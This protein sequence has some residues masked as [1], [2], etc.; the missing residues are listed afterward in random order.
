MFL[1]YALIHQIGKIKLDASNNVVPIINM[2]YLNNIYIVVPPLS[3]QKRIAKFLDE[4]CSKIDS[5][6]AKK[7]RQS[8]LMK[9]YKKSLIYEYVTGKKRT[10]E[11][12]G[13]SKR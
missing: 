9:E 2:S 13:N 1:L 6:F 7:E 8:Q 10:E 11:S 4:Q 5:I 3:E 12:H